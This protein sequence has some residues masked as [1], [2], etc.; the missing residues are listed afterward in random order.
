MIVM[1]PTVQVFSLTLLPNM[2]Q[3]NQ[4]VQAEEDSRRLYHEACEA[5]AAEE[6]RLFRLEERLICAQEEVN[7][8]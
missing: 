3:E 5:C 2:Q 1:I 6:L 8:L 4:L 7:G